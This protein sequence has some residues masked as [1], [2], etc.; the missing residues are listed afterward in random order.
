MD[1]EFQR[2]TPSSPPPLRHAIVDQR[3]SFILALEQLFK[4]GVHFQNVAY[5]RITHN[6]YVYIIFFL[7][8]LFSKSL[9]C[10][11]S[12]SRGKKKEKKREYKP[13]KP[14]NILAQYSFIL[15]ILCR[16]IY[17]PHT[18]LCVCTRIRT[19]QE[20]FSETRNKKK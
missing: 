16:K 9:H 10:I 7:G 2:E 18:T 8:I 11:L 19:N 13:E 20:E 5:T 6:S 17:L 1:F 14:Y 15:N 4:M 3:D 12:E